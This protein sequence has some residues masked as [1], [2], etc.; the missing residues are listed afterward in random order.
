MV[1]TPT[2]RCGT[3]QYTYDRV[4]RLVQADYGSDRTANFAYDNAGN[5][6]VSSSPTPGLALEETSGG[7]LLLSWPTLPASFSLQST[8]TLGA[9]P[10]WSAIPVVPIQVGNLWTATVPIGAGNLFYRL[11]K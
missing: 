8:S 3:I 5:T 10:T 7:G 6:L 4:G 1:A 9:G 2:V 11:A